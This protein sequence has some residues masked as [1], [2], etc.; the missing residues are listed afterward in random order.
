MRPLAPPDIRKRRRHP[1]VDRRRQQSRAD[2]RRLR[3]RRCCGAG[4]TH[5]ELWTRLYG[6]SFLFGFGSKPR[7]VVTEPE[8]IKEVMLDRPGRSSGLGSTRF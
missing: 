4:L 7:L 3:P 8:L 1:V 2:P 6:K 5:Y